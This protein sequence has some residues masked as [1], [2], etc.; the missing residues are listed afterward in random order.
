MNKKS[1]ALND[2]ADKLVRGNKRKTR[3]QYSAKAKI[4]LVLAFFRGG[5]SM[6]ALCCLEDIAV[7]L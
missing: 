3:K 6:P 1:G 2:A 4:S 7:R 5:E